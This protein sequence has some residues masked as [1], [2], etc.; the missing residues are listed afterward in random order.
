MRE[1]DGNCKI[2]NNVRETLQKLNGKL[3][4][5]F[6]RNFEN[7]WKINKGSWLLKYRKSS[8][9]RALLD[10]EQNEKERREQRLDRGGPRGRWLIE[11]NVNYAL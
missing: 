2:R 3:M 5:I 1:I 8:F 4:D 10:R 11:W 7:I 6:H 9:L